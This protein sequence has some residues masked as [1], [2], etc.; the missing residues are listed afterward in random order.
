MYNKEHYKEIIKNF[1]SNLKDI[2]ENIEWLLKRTLEV[3]KDFGGPSVYFHKMAIMEQR[4]NF[5]GKNHL[6]M[7]YALMPSWG[8]HRMGS[9]GAKMENFNVF[10]NEILKNKELLFELKNKKYIN[11]NIE[12]ILKLIT[13]YIH[14]SKSD[15]YLVSSSKVLH[16]IIPEIVSPIDRN[17]SIRFMQKNK[18]DWGSKSINIQN[19]KAY[20]QIFLEEMHKFIDKN[21]D[22]MLNYIV[23]VNNDNINDETFN[24]SLTKTFDNLI[25]TYVKENRSGL[26]AAANA[27]T[28]DD[29]PR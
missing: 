16:H 26:S 20:A 4:N 10:E 1:R 14:I 8:M 29:S 23:K 22:K 13:E 15:S 11:A 18:N 3:G 12:D 27:V 6:I 5:L 9:K 2:S 17:Y 24:T 19:E 25:M 7:I 21:G 28:A